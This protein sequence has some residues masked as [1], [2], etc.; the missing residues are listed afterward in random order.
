MQLMCNDVSNKK[1]EH[2]IAISTQD[3][4]V[5][6]NPK[7]TSDMFAE[8]LRLCRKCKKNADGI[9]LPQTCR[10]EHLQEVTHQNPPGKGEFTP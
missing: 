3:D 1:C 4:T 9:N 6:W 2:E 5:T 8:Q 7:M 10:K